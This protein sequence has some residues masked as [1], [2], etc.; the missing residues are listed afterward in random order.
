MVNMFMVSPVH[1]RVYT[2]LYVDPP[3]IID[4]AKTAGTTFPIYINVKNVTDL[5]VFDFTLNYDPTVLTANAPVTLGSFFPGDSMI[6]V[7]EIDNDLGYVR[8]LVSLPPG[9]QEGMS[10]SGTLATISFTVA[11]SGATILDLHDTK[12][13]DSH[14]PPQYIIHDVYDGYF[15]N[16]LRYTKLYVDPEN[17]INP[18]L[19]DG[20]NFTIN[21]NILNVTALYGFEFFLNYTTT[22]LT[23]T[24]VT[25]G[26]FSSGSQIV[27]EEIND[28]LGYVWYNITMPGVTGDGILANI[29]FTVDSIGESRLDLCNTKLVDS[30]GEQIEHDTMDGSF[31]NKEPTIDI[32]ITD[33]KTTVTTAHVVEGV[34]IL[35]PKAVS[36]VHSGDKLN[37]TVY[38]TNNGTSTETF[39]VTAY[40]GNNSISTQNVALL[41]GGFSKTVTIE[42]NTG[43]VAV[44]NY[45]IWAETSDVE[46]DINPDN[47]RFTMEDEFI[48][49][50]T[51]TI[52][53]ELVA[54]AGGI[55]LIVVAVAVYFLKFRKPKSVAEGTV[56]ESKG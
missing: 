55:V 53:I 49:S 8:Y 56:S 2:T 4:T 39:N 10:G 33:I 17:T 36:E 48:V 23:A 31:S 20:K 35:E 21:V 9:S 25:L 47:N 45:T 7:E 30:E 24:N 32:A 14:V 19:V 18:E 13:S 26:P 15:S 51:Q 41:E 22:V 28:T 52:P 42:W 37:V 6:W 46:G 16:I 38:V 43:G 50:W 44:G 27:H 5:L 3:S 11:G 54:A 34:T 1:G 40:Y 29:T 12:F